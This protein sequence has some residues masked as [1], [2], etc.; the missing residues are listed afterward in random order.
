MTYREKL[1][2]EFQ[3]F[4]KRYWRWS[5]IPL[6]IFLLWLITPP[7]SGA[8]MQKLVVAQRELAAAK[9]ELHLMQRAARDASAQIRAVTDTAAE[10]G[11]ALEEQRRRAEALTLDLEAE[12]HVI[13]DFKA[14]AILADEARHSLEVSLAEANRALD[15]ERHKVELSEHELTAVRQT[16]D[17]NKR[18]ADLAAVE[19]ANAVRDRQ[20]AEAALRQADDTLEL[21]RARGES[22]ARDLVSV[23]R[24]LD[25]ARRERDAARQVSVELSAALD[26]ER[27]RATSLARSLS[28]A[29][30]TIDIAKDELRTAA[31]VRTPKAR[32]P[33]RGLASTLSGAQP[34]RKPGLPEKQKVRDQKSPQHVLPATIALPA[35]L[36]P[37][38]PPNKLDLA[39]ED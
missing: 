27:E 6:C 28:A 38:R 25:S 8:D 9:A 7:D 34:A 22:T 20:V 29:R 11:Q 33:A 13:D 18:S 14:K 1:S 5:A 16:S 19:R 36:L 4:S 39:S 31:V 3:G 24:D 26:Q 10:Q 2:A 37:T 23:R 15:E 17:A 12:R 30:E 32:T 21:E 35:A